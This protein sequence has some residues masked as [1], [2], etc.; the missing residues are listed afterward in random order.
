[1]SES[2][3]AET[4][5]RTIQSL[6]IEHIEGQNHCFSW[7]INSGKYNLDTFWRPDS[8]TFF[9]RQRYDAYHALRGEA[10]VDFAALAQPDANGVL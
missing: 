1:M 6:I 2:S 9:F 10:S 5:R 3:A 8:A 4:V 7:H